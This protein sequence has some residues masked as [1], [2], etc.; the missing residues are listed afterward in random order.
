MSLGSGILAVAEPVRVPSPAMMSL[1]NFAAALA[2]HALPA[3]RRARVETLQVNVGRRCDLA[4]HHCHVEA[5]PKRTESMDAKTAARVIE[6]LASDP[7]VGTLD[8][9]GG[10]PELCENFR[11]LVSEARALG[12]AVIDRCNLTVLFEPGQEDTAEFLAGHGVKVVASLPCYTAGNVDAQRGKRVFERSVAA[13]QKLNA[14]G[15]ARPESGLALDLVYNP[16]GPSL[17]P[18]QS[19]LEATYR[20]ELREQ[21]GIEF[22]HLATITNMPIKRFAHA[23]ERDGRHAEYMGLLVNHFNPDTVPALMCRFLVSVGWDGALYDC[24]FNQ[25]LELPL[26]ADAKT[27]WDVDQLSELADAPIAIASHCFGC[28]A[29]S[30]SSCGGALA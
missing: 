21:F 13:L 30:G 14:L 26:G 23:L 19:G 28:T 7:G 11:F 29:G 4:C 9:T 10:A 2:E 25:M 12:R 17:P 18:D 16:L 24:D 1:P 5:G 3:L 8:L 27:I 15:Y 20:S 6:L 22:D